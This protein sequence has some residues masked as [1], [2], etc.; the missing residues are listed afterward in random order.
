MEKEMFRQYGYKF[1]DWLADYFEE[2]EEYPVLSPVKPGSVLNQLPGS[3]PSEG[4]SLE[5]IFEDFKK[6]II[7]GIGSGRA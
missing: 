4:E 5:T 7:P 1:V 3:P 2:I 6:I